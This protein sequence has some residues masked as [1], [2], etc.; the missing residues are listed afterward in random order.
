MNRGPILSFGWVF[1]G[2]LLIALPVIAWRR[3]RGGA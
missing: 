2:A 1:L 3:L